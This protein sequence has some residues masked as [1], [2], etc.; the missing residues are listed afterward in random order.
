MNMAASHKP[1]VLAALKERKYTKHKLLGTGAFAEVWAAT[2][3]TSGQQVAIKIVSRA[4]Y[5]EGLNLGAIKELQALGEL[6]A[7]P[8][9]LRLLDVYVATEKLH[10][11]LE[12][13]DCELMDMIV[14]GE[15][16]LADAKAWAWQLLAGLSAMHA[17][18]TLHRGT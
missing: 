10:V 17:H 16:H 14:K 6:G 9:I 12:K 3:N 11:V 2:C 7:H 8:N 18:W 13:A 1:E 5:E 15:Y 4:K